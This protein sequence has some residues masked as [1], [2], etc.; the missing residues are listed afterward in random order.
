MDILP[1]VRVLPEPPWWDTEV[2]VT[3]D[4]AVELALQSEW[5]Q[6]P[7]QE[8]VRALVD[9]YFQALFASDSERLHPV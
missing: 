8:W 6:H 9:T 7:D 2:S 4:Q 1:D 3:P 5:L